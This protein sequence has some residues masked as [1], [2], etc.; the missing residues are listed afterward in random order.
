VGGDVQP[1]T[2]IV[3]S[4]VAASVTTLRSLAA[5]HSSTQPEVVLPPPVPVTG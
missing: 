2:H 5:V 3:N 1:G 4:A